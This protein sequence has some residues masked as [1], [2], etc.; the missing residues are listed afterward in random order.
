MTGDELLDAYR[1]FTDSAIRLETLQHYEV[2]G[3]EERQQAFKAGMPL[4]GRAEKSETIQLIEDATSAGRRFGRVHVVDRPLSDY[5]RYELEA[6]YAENVAAGEK[7]LIADRSADEAL[8]GLREDFVLFDEDTDHPSVI[9]YRYSADG[10]I[11]GWDAGS[12]DDVELCRAVL[13]L[14]RRHAIP[15]AEFLTSTHC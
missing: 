6:A 4:P 7:I 15:L 13:D 9:W 14:A 11:L 12:A 8:D 1:S 5:V 3:D 2:P 10:R